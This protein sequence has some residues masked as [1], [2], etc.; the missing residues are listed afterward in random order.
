MR[1]TLVLKL[2]V[3]LSLS[4]TGRAGIAV[5]GPAAGA[6]ENAAGSHLGILPPDNPAASLRPNPPFLASCQPGNDGAEC[7]SLVLTA[8]SRARQ[9]LEK[10]GGMSFSLASYL[11]L[12]PG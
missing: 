3:L 4:A 9:T 11:K 2:T 5:T 10:I 7:D 8:I 12:T 1:T 6:Q